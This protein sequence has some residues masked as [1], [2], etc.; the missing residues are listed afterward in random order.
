MNRPLNGYAA[1]ARSH[2][3]TLSG[4]EIEA[5]A[6]LKSVRLLRDAEADPADINRLTQ[7][8]DY[9]LRLWTVF[10]ADLLSVGCPL[11]ENV[12]NDLLRLCRFVALEIKRA[13]E[14]PGRADLKPMREINQ[15]LA[16][17]LL[18]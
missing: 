4:R 2:A 10:E 15:T 6:L 18:N 3:G 11:P 7:A 14:A 5:E 16:S 17:G 9:N 1:Y 12:R 8:L 13:V